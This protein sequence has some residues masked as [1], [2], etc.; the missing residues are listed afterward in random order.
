MVERITRHFVL[1]AFGSLLQSALGF[2][3]AVEKKIA[4]GKIVVGKHEIGVGRDLRPGHL[5]GS[6]IPACPMGGKA[7]QQALSIWRRAAR[8]GPKPRLEGQV[9]LFQISRHMP[10]VGKVDEK[11]LAVAD[12]FPQF[13]GLCGA[14]RR[15]DRLSH[16]AVDEPQIRVGH[17]E[18]RIDFDGTPVK[19][20]ARR[21]GIGQGH[22]QGC[23]VP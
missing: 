14:L 7:G 1:S 10:V 3:E 4:R 17:C 13:P 16:R 12:S 22:L 21:I 23:A 8:I 18:L 9:R 6:F 20:N 11:P 19:G 5:D 2:G 15:Q